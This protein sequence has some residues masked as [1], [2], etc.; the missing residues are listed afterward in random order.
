MN[1]L[2]KEIV[3]NRPVI[4]DGAWGTMLQGYGLSPGECPD[5]W[6]LTHPEQVEKI[7]RAYVEAG[8]RIILTNTFRSNRISL[9]GYGLDEK[10]AEINRAGVKLS[11]KAAGNR[12]MVFGSIGPSGKML[13]TGEVTEEELSRAFEEQALAMAEAGA[14]GIVLETMSDLTEIKLAA[15]A[16][17][18]SGLPVIGSMVFDSGKNK[19]H[20]MMGVSVEEAAKELTSAGVD[21]VGANCGQGIEGFLEICSRL[22]KS[23]HLPVW[24]KPNAGLPEFVD[25]R[26]VYKMNPEEFAGY[27][28]D[29]VERGADFVGGCCGTTPEFIIAI[30]NKLHKEK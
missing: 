20:T 5:G 30:K 1:S 15:A 26:I 19:D 27:I 12:A 11:K 16:A 4:T 8:S 22:R 24:I 13:M 3:G 6:N 25:G 23:T 9:A 28:P 29:L 14:D 18:K 7:A 2:I 21:V 17:K 10:T